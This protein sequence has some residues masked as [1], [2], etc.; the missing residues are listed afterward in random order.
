M[1]LSG[2][3]VCRRD[4]RRAAIDRVFSGRAWEAV[5]RFLLVPRLR[6][7]T[8]CFEPLAR[9]LTN[10]TKKQHAAERSGGMQARQPQSCH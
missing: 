1:R 4:S 8:G 2:P 10:E 7:G 5:R 6:L 3:A 9:P